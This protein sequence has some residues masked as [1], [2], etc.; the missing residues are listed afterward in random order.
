MGSLFSIY[1]VYPN[2]Y[3]NQIQKIKLCHQDETRVPIRYSCC[4]RSCCRTLTAAGMTFVRITACVWGETGAWFLT[5]LMIDI[6]RVENRSWQKRDK[7]HNFSNA[8]Y[9]SLFDDPSFF[10]ES[11]HPLSGSCV[12]PLVDHMNLTT[13]L[14]AKVRWKPHKLFNKMPNLPVQE[15]HPAFWNLTFE[16]T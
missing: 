5:T 7:G 3:T 10:P 13:C 6:Q 8:I 4:N 1:E 9:I 2:I 12:P 15:K 14:A 16:N 11:A